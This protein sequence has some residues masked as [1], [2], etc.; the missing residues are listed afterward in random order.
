MGLDYWALVD[1]LKRHEGFSAVPYYCSAGA[2][3]I[4]H[5]RNLD[6]NWFSEVEKAALN[7][8]RMWSVEPLTEAEAEM[9]L[10]A[11]IERTLSECQRQAWWA[12]LCGPHKQVVANMVFNLGLAGF[13]G[14]G[15]AVAALERGDLVTAGNEFR[16]SLWYKQVGHRSQELV[17][18]WKRYV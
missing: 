18:L 3:T 5:G 9:L 1:D 14:F 8:P 7:C 17:A 12:A 11:D 16:R 15:D 13:L 6:A 4:G 10:H 2:L